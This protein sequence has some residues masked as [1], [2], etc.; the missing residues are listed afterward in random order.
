M[1]VSD[2]TTRDAATVA[3]PPKGAAGSPLRAPVA[4]AGRAVVLY[5]SPLTSGSFGH[6][7]APMMDGSR[8]KRLPAEETTC[9]EARVQTPMNKHRKHGSVAGVAHSGCLGDGRAV[10][11]D[12]PRTGVGLPGPADIGGLPAGFPPPVRGFEHA[13]R[14]VFVTACNRGHGGGCPNDRI[15]PDGS[16]LGR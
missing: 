6:T 8:P 4:F 1:T 2:M 5:P 3:T 10:R 14:A 7:S 16:R 11:N 12:E 13:G 15:H 9:E